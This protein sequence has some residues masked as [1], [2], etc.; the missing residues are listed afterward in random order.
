MILDTVIISKAASEL[1]DRYINDRFM[2][3]KAID[4]ID[5]AGASE[6]AA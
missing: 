3:D 6:I 5:E 2:P 1:V 4:V